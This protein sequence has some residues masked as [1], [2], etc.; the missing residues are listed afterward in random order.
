[1]VI[2]SQSP[3]AGSVPV[4]DKIDVGLATDY[5]LESLDKYTLYEITVEA[6]GNNGASLAATPPNPT[7]PTDQWIYLGLLSR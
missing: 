5:K 4:Q 2:N 6:V 3:E 7:M 1:M